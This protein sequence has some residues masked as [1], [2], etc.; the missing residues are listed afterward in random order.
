MTYCL[1]VCEFLYHECSAGCLDHESLYSIGLESVLN[2]P[3]P[4][5]PTIA[6]ASLRT[7][8]L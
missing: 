1:H 2:N 7:T 8:L 5:H 3:P 6:Y 4:P